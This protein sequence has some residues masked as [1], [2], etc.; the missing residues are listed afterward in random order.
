MTIDSRRAAE[1]AL[2]RPVATATVTDRTAIAYDPYLAGRVVERRT[3]TARTRD[4]ESV[5][6]T[7]V[8]KR[9]EGPGLRAARREL[10][11]YRDGP[12]TSAPST[13][14]RAP[15]LL[16]WTDDDE[17]VELWLED[18]SDEHRG[19]CTALLVAGRLGQLHVAGDRGEQPHALA[20]GRDHVGVRPGLG[21]GRLGS[22]LVGLRLGR[23][24][25][26]RRRVLLCSR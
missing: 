9:T 16:G 26:G 12:A 4:G 14:L 17:H 6:F 19:R 11:A 23:S 5:R 2:R 10:A 24:R 18:L 21:L 8:V 1:V 20:Q 3:V 13:G 25:R 22:R 7:V 15:A